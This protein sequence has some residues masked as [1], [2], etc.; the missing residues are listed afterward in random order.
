M[1]KKLFAILM[2]ALSVSAVAQTKKVAIL[3]TVDRD[4]K[5]TYGV[6][7]MVR[8]NLAEAVATTK[9]YEAY[10]RTNLDKILDEQT[11]QRTGYVS[12]E[13]IREI[14]NMTG[15]QYI[16]VAEASKV[17]E[18]HVFVTAKI[19][20]VVTARTE[21]I[22]SQL[23]GITPE[24][25]QK[26]C[27]TL[28]SKLLVV[29]E[30]PEASAEIV[31]TEQIERVSKNEYKLGSIWMTQKE[32]YQFINNR[33]RCV[34]A[35]QQFQQGLKLE[36]YGKWTT[37]AGAGVLLVGTLTLAIGVPVNA[38][39]ADRY[40]SWAEY[41]YDYYSNYSETKD[42]TVKEKGYYD[43]YYHSNSDR[44]WNSSSQHTQNISYGE[45]A[46]YYRDA[47][48]NCLV[49]GSV[50]MG[51]GAVVAVPGGILWGVGISKKNNAYKAYNQ[52]CAEPLTLNFQ[53]TGNG[54]GLA[55]RF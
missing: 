26:G 54:L 19:L 38:K 21:N 32:Y 17:D 10:D 8:S 27:Q 11:F 15:V 36:K 37:V 47:R 41:Y 9:G 30:E 25:I 48:V 12:D 24:Q 49:A 53:Y 3:E 18:A 22:S 55:L 4:N 13:Q 50:L 2:I 28:A 35:Y 42:F 43:G 39:K 7:L 31:S 6:R 20:D 40:R 29:N 44:Y 33:D 5:L 52:H 1:K 46:V 45:N 34:P 51:V 23:L 16:L 14:G